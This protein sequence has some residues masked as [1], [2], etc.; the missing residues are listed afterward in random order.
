MGEKQRLAVTPAVDEAVTAALKEGHREF[1]RFVT[2]RTGRLAD[3][4]DI[5]QDF[6]LKAVVRASTIRNTG[7]VKSWLAKVLRTTL[8][9]YYRRANVRRRLQERLE[10]T[11]DTSLVIDDEAERAVCACLYRILPTLPADYAQ[12][13]WRVDLLG[14]PRSKVARS[15]RISPNNLGVRIHRARQALRAALERYCTTCPIHGFLSCACDENRRRRAERDWFERPATVMLRHP[16]RLK[17]S[18]SDVRAGGRRSSTPKPNRTT[19]SEG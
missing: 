18:R 19:P 10:G 4:E 17:S 3:A 8:A 14:Q 9:D 11:R 15:L 13:I 1:L 16:E 5:L 12:I 7:S 6:Y 2:R